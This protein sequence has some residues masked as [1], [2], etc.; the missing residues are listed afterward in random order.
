MQLLTRGI[1]FTVLIFKILIFLQLSLQL[2]GYGENLLFFFLIS[3]STWIFLFE[4]SIHVYNYYNNYSIAFDGNYF[5]SQYS[6]SS[7]AR[8]GEQATT[9]PNWNRNTAGSVARHFKD[10]SWLMCPTVWLQSGT[11]SRYILSIW[12]HEHFMNTI[13]LLKTTNDKKIFWHSNCFHK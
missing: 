13:F 7:G 11:L 4:Q 3:A 10:T 8:E 9:G 1:L 5:Q 12:S 2:T 6:K